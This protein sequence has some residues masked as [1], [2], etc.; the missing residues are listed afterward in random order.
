MV[1]EGRS[2]DNRGSCASSLFVSCRRE[3]VRYKIEFFG[4]CEFAEEKTPFGNKKRPYGRDWIEPP[5]FES[6]TDSLMYLE[7]LIGS[8]NNDLPGFIDPKDDRVLIWEILPSGHK[9]VVWHFSGWHWACDE[10]GIEQG[11][12]LGHEES[13]YS[14]M[15]P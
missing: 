13:L 6:L 12:L 4:D 5:L 8:E 2:A 11:T 15:D 9:K 3:E 1:D 14:E 7:K 10:F